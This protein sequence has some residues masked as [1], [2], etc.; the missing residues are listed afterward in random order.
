MYVFSS[1][2]FVMK[3]YLS[4]FLPLNYHVDGSESLENKF[5]R[6]VDVRDVA[7]ALLLA[8]QKPEAKGRY[9]CIAHIIKAK[10]LIDLLKSIYP[11]YNY[12]KR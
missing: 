12:P 9:I 5:R 11:N 1:S 8:Y 10:D 6:I 4:H 2:F 7:E 3:V